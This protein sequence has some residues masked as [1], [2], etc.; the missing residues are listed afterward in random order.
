V[1]SGIEIVD[2][3]TWAIAF[4]EG[5]GWS[6]NVTF[7]SLERDHLLLNLAPQSSCQ[8]RLASSFGQLKLR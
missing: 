4:A 5:G 7:S 3:D 1:D 8:R 2:A 6:F